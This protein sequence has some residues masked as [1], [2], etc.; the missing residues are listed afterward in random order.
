MKVQ[1]KQVARY[2]ISDVEECVCS[3]LSMIFLNS[4]L[5]TLN[6]YLETRGAMPNIIDSYTHDRLRDL[7]DELHVVSRENNEHDRD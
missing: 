3:A 5:E 4:T 6:K 7:A 1:K 2:V